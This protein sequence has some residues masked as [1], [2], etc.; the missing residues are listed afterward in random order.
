MLR[1]RRA[2]GRRYRAQA[3]YAAACIM[4][5]HPKVIDIAQKTA[6]TLNLRHAKKRCRMPSKWGIICYL[7][8]CVPRVSLCHKTSRV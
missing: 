6:I 3:R 5:P 8:Y 2:M 7:V 4:R 1:I